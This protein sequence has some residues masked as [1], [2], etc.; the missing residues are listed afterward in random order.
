MLDEGNVWLR[1]RPVHRLTVG[2]GRVRLEK[3]KKVGLI[4]LM[5]NLFFC[6]F[7]SFD[8]KTVVRCPRMSRW[9]SMLGSLKA[10]S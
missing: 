5:F 7:N 8:S 6:V 4:V 2:H 10:K 1:L 9:T 3:K